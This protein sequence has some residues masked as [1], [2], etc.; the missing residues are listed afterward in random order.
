MKEKKQTQKEGAR[1]SVNRK[2]DIGTEMT[3]GGAGVDQYR[4]MTEKEVET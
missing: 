2:Q 4:E 3:G 1:E